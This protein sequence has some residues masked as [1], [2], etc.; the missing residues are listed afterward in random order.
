[1]REGGNLG[2]LHALVPRFLKHPQ[3]RRG[4]I[5]VVVRHVEPGTGMGVLF[6]DTPDDQQ[7]ILDAWLA[8]LSTPD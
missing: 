8:Q 7:R 1:V 6:I 3:C 5:G 2:L 4:M